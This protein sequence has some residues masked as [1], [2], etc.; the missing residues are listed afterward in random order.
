MRLAIVQ[1][2]PWILVK[3]LGITVKKEAVEVME[4]SLWMNVVKPQATK[5]FQKWPWQSKRSPRK[6]AQNFFVFSKFCDFKIMKKDKYVWHGA[7]VVV[8]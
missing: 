2:G 7:S 3:S 1:P 6:G 8:G 5:E 4:T